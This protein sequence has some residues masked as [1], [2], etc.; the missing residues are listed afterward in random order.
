MLKYTGHP[1]VDVGIATITAFANKHD[2]T[3]LTE[4]DLHEIA[5]FM[6]REYPKS[7]YKSFLSIA[8]TSNAWFIQDAYNPDKPN[9]SEEKR[10][11]I[12][13]TRN[14]WSSHHLL[15]WGSDTERHS[16]EQDVFTGVPAANVELSGKL[17]PGR[18][19]RAQVPLLSG[20]D[21]INF[22]A[23]GLP[24]IPVSGETLLC[25][26]ALPLGCA[27]CGGKLLIVHSDN[28]D[29]MQHF[30]AKFLETNRRNAQV[31]QLTGETK[32]PDAQYSQKTL[33]IDTLL[34]SKEMQ[35][36]AVKDA[37]YF[38]ITAY[39]LSN[40]GQ[41]PG[42]IIYHLPLQAIDFLREVN[43]AE[44]RWHWNAVVQRAWERAPLK[45]K[46]KAEDKPF[47]RKR[48]WLYEDLFDLPANAAQFIRTYFLRVAL[49][50]ARG[51][52]D[53][54]VDY[55]VKTEVEL[56][57]WKITAIFLRR[58]LNMDKQRIDQIRS[59]GDQL[60]EYVN[61]QNDRR[62]FREF[63]T[64]QSYSNLRNALIKASVA[65]VKRGNAPIITLDP[66]VEVF[67]EGDELAR[68]D[69]R[70]A[71]DLVLIRMVERLYTL[72]WLGK[73]ADVLPESDQTEVESN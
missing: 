26:Q 2:P 13:Q 27:K 40:S 56:V 20:D 9:L 36:D 31:A 43:K 28:H 58:I 29:I 19:G 66:Y 11:E 25:L 5:M 34:N 70:L 51:E 53:P 62:F 47:E 3:E 16:S 71:R 63:Y 21:S 65:H 33:L 44:N 4:A 49:R 7:P 14:K 38:S 59:M 60:A 12:L 42:L 15:Q 52:S 10:N 55:S 72:N 37:Q 1:L 64:T 73:N 35:S 57:S 45:Q 67:E 24:G 46:K 23:N 69:W 39:H 41:G 30:A 32:M 54:R 68:T 6:A 48:N 50:Y 8:F 22:Y 61:S 17:P 18:A